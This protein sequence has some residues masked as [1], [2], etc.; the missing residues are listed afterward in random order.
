MGHFPDH[1]YPNGT[2][3]I[4]FLF[5]LTFVCLSSSAGFAEVTLDGSMGPRQNLAGPTY[6][7]T[8]DLGTFTP[9]TPFS[10]RY[11]GVYATGYYYDEVTGLIS[12]GP[13]TLNVST[14]NE[15]GVP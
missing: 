15:G 3:K 5:Y 7:I 9:T 4:V 13:V 2:R 10:S 1:R 11:V 12:T 8:S 14:S 6:Q